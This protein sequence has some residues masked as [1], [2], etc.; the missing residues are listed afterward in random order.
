MS[1]LSERLSCVENLGKHNKYKNITDNNYDSDSMFKSSKFLEF[2]PNTPEFPVQG[3]GSIPDSTVIKRSKEI[4]RYNT[5]YLAED[6][7]YVNYVNLNYAVKN[8]TIDCKYL[9]Y[10]L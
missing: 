8:S 6:F 7:Y 10:F 5:N 1:L 2:A 4:N 9:L 3:Y